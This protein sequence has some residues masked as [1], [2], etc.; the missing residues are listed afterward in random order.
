MLGKF[1]FLTSSRIHITILGTH[2][3][4]LC[5]IWKDIRIQTFNGFILLL[6]FVPIGD[7]SLTWYSTSLFNWIANERSGGKPAWVRRYITDNQIFEIPGAPS[8]ELDRTYLHNTCLAIH[9][10]RNLIQFW[11]Q[12]TTWR[13]KKLKLLRP[14]SPPPSAFKSLARVIAKSQPPSIKIYSD[15]SNPAAFYAVLYGRTLSLYQFRGNLQCL[16]VILS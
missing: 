8:S 16:L 5:C 9:K 2:T 6:C 4:Y 10:W 1:Y 11:L 12:F 3:W 13:T 14:R 7:D 15:T